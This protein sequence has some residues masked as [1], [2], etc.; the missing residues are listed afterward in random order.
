MLHSRTPQVHSIKDI[1]LG[2]GGKVAED[3][4][5]QVPPATATVEQ[6]LGFSQPPWPREIPV[7]SFPPEEADPIES[8]SP[9]EADVHEGAEAE[10][11]EADRPPEEPPAAPPRVE[12]LLTL[13]DVKDLEYGFGANGVTVQNSLHARHLT[14]RY[15]MKQTLLAGTTTI[16]YKAVTDKLR[17]ARGSGRKALP[18]ENWVAAVQAGCNM[19]PML[20]F[21]GD[22]VNIHPIPEDPQGRVG[23]HNSLMTLCGLSL[24]ELVEAIKSKAEGPATKRHKPA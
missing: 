20:T 2:E 6:L 3:T 5:D 4:A 11:P 14:D 19:C 15:I 23:Y 1:A 8:P 12:Q 22:T 17:S 13:K 9:N 21:Q 16:R 10:G 7:D 24:R 18:K